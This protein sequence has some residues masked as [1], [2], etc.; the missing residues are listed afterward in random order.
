MN[1]YKN[2]ILV[3][4]VIV[5][6]FIGG[7]N[8]ALQSKAIE[9]DTS[10]SSTNITTLGEGVSETQT[11]TTT[12]SES[13][14]ET[15]NSFTLGEGVTDIVTTELTENTVDIETTIESDGSTETMP[16][17]SSVDTVVDTTIDYPEFTTGIS[18]WY[19]TGT[20][21]S[22]IKSTIISCGCF[23]RDTTTIT[24]GNITETTSTVAEQ[25]DGAPKT[26]NR[27]DLG[28][29]VMAGIVGIIMLI[30]MIAFF[31]KEVEETEK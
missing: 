13:A 2:F 31:K 24:T 8:G 21:T 25:I 3:L 15:T 16:T 22:E 19:E 6:I 18:A 17:E 23:E 20:S 26:G 10:L 1:I 5:T 11:S 28:E 4:A 9:V 12:D 30:I 7:E 29:A 27:F 14:E